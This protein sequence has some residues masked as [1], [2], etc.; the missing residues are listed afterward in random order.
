MAGLRIREPLGERAATLPLTL[1]GP[2]ADVVV[3]GFE[4]IG[5]TLSGSG[6][7]WMAR[8]VAGATLA[9]NGMPLRSDTAVDAG[10]VIGIGQAQVVVDPAGALLEVVHLAGN[11]T[12]APVRRDVLPGEEITAGVREIFATAASPVAGQHGRTAAQSRR[13]GRYAYIAAGVVIAALAGLL[14][15]LVSVP[16]QLLPEGTKVQATGWPAWQGGDRLYLLPGRRVLTFTHGGYRTQQLTLQVTPALSAAE[17]LRIELVKLPGRVTVDTGGVPAELLVDGAP[18]GNLPG[19]V[20]IEAGMHQLLVRAPRHVEQVLQLEVAGKDEAQRVAVALLPAIGWL[21]LDTVPAAAR[22]TIDGQD[23][24][25]APQKLELDSGLRQLSLSA[26]GRRSWHSEVAIIAGQTLDLGR[27]DLAL[28]PPMPPVVAAAAAAPAEA[29]GEAVPVAAPAPKAPPPARLRSELLGTLVLFPAGRYT[30]GSERR[31]QGRRANETQRQVTLTRAFYL[32]ET[33]VTNAQFRAF[34]AGH[35]SGLAMDKSLDLDQQAVSNVGWNDAVE[36]CNW[37]SLREGLPA[38]YER[39]DGRWQLVQP[40]NQG[41]RLPTEAEWEYAG[42][43]IDGQRWQR[44]PWG[45]TLPPPTQAANLAGQESLPQKPGPDLRLAA[46]LPNYRDAHA[47]IAPVGSYMRSATGLSDMG[48]NVSEWM[49]DVYV[50]LP[51][52]QPVSDPVGAEA[53]GAHAIRGASWRT[54]AIAELRLAWRERATAA[55]DHTG[56]RVARHAPEQP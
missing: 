43:Y 6:R 9:L 4:A 21:Q 39:R 25:V 28:P 34:R 47:V 2:E 49:H 50:S 7:Q 48:G 18:A 3:P 30:Q 44:Y 16:L 55:N 54:A 1:G 12:V 20:Q 40:V 22:I 38:A 56:F 52:S 19:E 13:G 35:V 51:E 23:L 37:L 24:G 27:V 8:P 14:F 36:F 11:D 45:D 53:D 31:E 10:D 42:R 29:V 41:Y 46:S 17:P 15:T 32:A 5:L 26:P 33:E